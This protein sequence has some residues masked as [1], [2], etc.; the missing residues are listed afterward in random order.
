MGVRLLAVLGDVES[1]A[2]VALAEAE[3]AEPPQPRAD[4]DVDAV[5]RE[6]RLRAVVPPR[7]DDERGHERREAGRHLGES[8]ND[9]GDVHEPGPDRRAGP[10]SIC[11]GYSEFDSELRPR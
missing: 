4:E 3:P 11:R 7:A 5:V 9:A 8:R 6:Y 2:L 1:H 10:G